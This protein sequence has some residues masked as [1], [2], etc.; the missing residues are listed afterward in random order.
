MDPQQPP[1]SP[2]PPKPPPSQ[3][4]DQD[5]DALLDSL[6]KRIVALRMETPAIFFLESVKPMNFVGSQAMVFFRPLLTAFFPAAKLDRLSAALEKRE[7]IEFL[8]QK[9][10]KASH[11]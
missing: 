3:S 6:A 2:K 11:A 1:E 9:I 7:T 8:I 4:L 5:D 10:E